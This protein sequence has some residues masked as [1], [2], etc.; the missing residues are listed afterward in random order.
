MRSLRLNLDCYSR[1]EPDEVLLLFYKPVAQ[2]P[3]PKLTII[4]RHLDKGNRFPVCWRLAD[5]V[6]VP[7][8]T[9]STDFGFYT[10]ISITPL[11]SK[12]FKKKLSGKLS[13]M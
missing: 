12:V 5:V 10:L 9:S 1:N 8:E 7:K 4:F 13:Y 2:E 6:P 11:L 3:V